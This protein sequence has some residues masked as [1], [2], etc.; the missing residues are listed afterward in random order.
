[1]VYR[2]VLPQWQQDGLWLMQGDLRYLIPLN[3]PLYPLLLSVLKSLFGEL[4]NETVAAVLFVQHAVF[5]MAL[6]YFASFFRR[7]PSRLIAVFFVVWPG[8]TLWIVNGIYKQGLG[9]SFVLL[10]VACVFRLAGRDF[11][12][13][14]HWVGLFGTLYLAIV[15]RYPS[16]ILLGLAPLALL[17][18]FAVRPSRIALKT[19]FQSVAV[20]AGVSAAVLGT[21]VAANLAVG[22]P[23]FLVS[24]GMIVPFKLA[25]FHPDE[26]DLEN[27]T[28]SAVVSVEDPV[29]KAVIPIA[30]RTEL[31]DVPGGMV[32]AIQS[33]VKKRFGREI[34][35]KEAERLISE[36]GATILRTSTYWRDI[37]NP[38]AI[39]L[40][41]LA[42]GRISFIIRSSN[43][44]A[45]DF[46]A[47]E[48]AKASV[49]VATPI[50][51]LSEA[52]ILRNTLSLSSP[53]VSFWQLRWYADPEAPF[54][55]AVTGL[56]P[57]RDFRT[58]YYLLA[59]LLLIAMRRRFPP[60][61]GRSGLAATLIAIGVTALAFV[62]IM[63]TIHVFAVSYSL[64][65]M[66]LIRTIIASQAAVTVQLALRGCTGADN[67]NRLSTPLP[68]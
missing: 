1:M 56:V 59:P 35:I 48:A 51:S 57:H 38:A 13:P 34:G 11:H 52:A 50:S 7:L 3:E 40:H 25:S 64:T 29:L 53:I 66:L 28:R 2:F 6:F 62:I 43:T 26:Q 14:I 45:R 23:P 10:T 20:S 36:A 19:F 17:L 63:G 37:W 46:L 18:R 55:E 47:Q 30:C 32:S 22:N 49:G 21:Y 42:D 5:S 9:I 60:P 8:S 67:R 33:T 68:T 24:S 15:T 12:R 54:Q 31:L 4:T 39:G 27:L 58:W 65:F 44:T 16:G 61:T 41:L